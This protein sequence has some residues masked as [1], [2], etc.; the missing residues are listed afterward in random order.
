MNFQNRHIPFLVGILAWVLLLAGCQVEEPPPVVDTT[1]PGAISDLSAT[2][3][4][5]STGTITLAW[6]AVGDD[7]A[8]GGP[9]S[10]YEIRFAEFVISESNWSTATTYFQTWTPV[11]PG[12]GEVHD[13]PG[14]ASGR[15]FFFAIRVFDDAGNPSPLSNVAST[16]NGQDTI[17][18]ANITDLS[19][20]TSGSPEGAV[21]LTWTAVGDDGQ[22]NGPASAY[23]VRYSESLITESTW[24][25]ATVHPQAWTPLPPGQ[26]E[27]A[28]IQGL[29]PGTLY[30]FGI[31]VRDEV[32]NVSGLSFVATATASTDTTPPAAIT[33]LTASTSP[34]TAGGVVL[35]WTAVGE[36]GASGGAATAYEVRTSSTPIN[37]TNWSAATVVAQNW[38][39]LAPG[40][41]ENHEVSGFTPG[42]TVHIAIRV[43]DEVPNTSPPSNDASANALTGW[44]WDHP[45][46]QGNYLYGLWG[47]SGTDVFAVGSSNSILHWDGSRWSTMN[48]AKTSMAFFDVWGA[49]G[50]DVFAVGGYRTFHTFA[51]QAYHYDG[52]SWSAMTLP[53]AYTPLYGVWGASGT[54]VFAVG[55]GG[56]I[57]QY[58]GAV[59][60]AMT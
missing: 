51:G 5:G 42:A 21:D 2:P 45:T 9:A 36:D 57:F 28:Q 12:D 32:P 18:P 15:T 19:A 30:Y 22:G 17:A 34:G 27:T 35:Q 13:C 53:N 46:P 4:A 52:T 58:N 7:G 39:P 29:N 10:S 33:D 24:S 43:S 25:S 20:S 40:Q 31:K 26:T 56:R 54:N 50:T 60:T 14:F 44:V 41:T 49:S 47:A 55:M 16:S 48:P 1:P 3:A 8:G 37:A 23:E 59:W 6:T 38:V 11:P